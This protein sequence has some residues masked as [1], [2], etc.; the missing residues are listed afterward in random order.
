M[1]RFLPSTT[2]AIL[3]FFFSH[4]AQAHIGDRIFPIYEISDEDLVEIDVRDGSVEDWLVITGEPSIYGV[5]FSSIPYGGQLGVHESPAPYRPSDLDFRIWLGWNRNSHL[6]FFGYEGADDVYFNEYSGEILFDILRNDCVS[7]MIDG[8]HSAGDYAR[9]EADFSEEER[10]LFVERS[11]QDYM[12]IAE[13]PEGY[14]VGYGGAGA[15]WVNVPPY[16]E[17]FGAIVGESPTV[18]V[19]EFFAT[20]FDDLIWN[21][22]K[23]S[24]P[25]DLFPGK[26]IGFISVRQATRQER[27]DY[28]AGI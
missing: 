17:G 23:E 28:E 11:A 18:S 5:G 20:P 21:N 7:F 24:A 3:T 16:T 10:T 12:A 8:D 19:I 9:G 2:G 13:A 27:K 4:S 26:I 1:D 14:S 15:S 22:P 25:T 6:L